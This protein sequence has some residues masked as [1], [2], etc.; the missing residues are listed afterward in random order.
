MRSFLL[1]TYRNVEH[2]T[3][4]YEFVYKN[5]KPNDKSITFSGNQFSTFIGNKSADYNSYDFSMYRTLDYRSFDY[6][7]RLV[8]YEPT[9]TVYLNDRLEGVE[10]MTEPVYLDYDK[11]LFKKTII[12]RFVD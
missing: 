8:N 1:F 6:I 9:G 3:I 12:N 11:E 2:D 4:N 10:N 5:N 7:K